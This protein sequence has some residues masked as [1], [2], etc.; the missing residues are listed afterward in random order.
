[1][2]SVKS[3]AS[4]PLDC[5][6]STGDCRSGMSA[7]MI[8]GGKSLQKFHNT[9]CP[10]CKPIRT[11]DDNSGA[12]VRRLCSSCRSVPSPAGTWAMGN[13]NKQAC[14]F[15]LAGDSKMQGSNSVFFIFVG[16]DPL[17]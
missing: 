3:L 9:V 11:V 5:G 14:F 12:E 6:A 1:M 2:P 8:T 13:P 15:N 4:A 17:I 16:F 10:D 7:Y